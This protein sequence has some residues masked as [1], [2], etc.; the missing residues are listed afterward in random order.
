M[1]KYNTLDSLLDLWREIQLPV[2]RAD[3]FRLLYVFA[4][5]GVYVDS[6][7]AAIVPID[8]WLF[9]SEWADETLHT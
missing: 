4:E 7:M 3:L 9:E 8:S 1:H 5:G 2:V 6:D